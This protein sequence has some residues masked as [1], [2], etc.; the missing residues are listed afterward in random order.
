MFGVPSTELA[1]DSLC[2]TAETLKDKKIIEE[3]ISEP[4]GGA[5]RD[6]LTTIKNVENSIKNSIEELIDVS[7]LELIRIRSKKFISY[8]RL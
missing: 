4:I 6:H 1:A 8:G 5:H 3:I 7:P 2:I